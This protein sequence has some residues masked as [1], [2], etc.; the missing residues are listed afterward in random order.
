MTRRRHIPLL[1]TVAAIPLVALAVAGCGGGGSATAW[2]Q[3]ATTAAGQPATVGVASNGALG[4]ILVD[5]QGRTLYLFQA[6]D[7][8]RARAPARARPP[9]RRCEPPASPSPEA[10]SARAKLTIAPRSDGNPQ[11]VYNG[12][13][14]YRFES[15][16][17][18]G[19]TSGQGVSAFGAKW[20][21]VSP[22]GATITATNT[23]GRRQQ[24]L[25]TSSHRQPIWACR[26]R[27]PSHPPRMRRVRPC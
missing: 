23:L 10:A 5:S 9:G 18:P 22:A 4:K 15:D 16:Q 1:T 6:D 26:R 21:V 17:K 14:L 13:P 2:T 3:P 27:P 8:T 20:F 24:W 19:D 12:H 25:L 7:G 11:V